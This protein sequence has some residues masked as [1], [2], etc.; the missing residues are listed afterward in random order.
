MFDLTRRDILTQFAALALFPSLA[1]ASDTKSPLQFDPPEPFSFDLLVERAREMASRPYHPETVRNGDVLQRIDFDEHWKI[2]YRPEATLEI[3]DGKAPVRFFHLGRYFQL[4]VNIHVVGGDTSQRLIYD[5]SLFCMPDDSPAR[6]LPHDIGFAGFRVLDPGKETDWLAI[7]GAAYFRSSGQSG[8]YGLSARAVALDTAMPT[9]EEFPRFT[10]F[11][12]APS[13]HGT[14]VINCLING[15]R[16][17]G[18]FR[19][20]CKKDGPVVMDISARFFARQDIPRVGLAPL[21]SMFWYS[22]TDPSRRKDWRPEIHDSDGLAIWSGNGERLWRPLNDPHRV[23]TSS[24]M[25]TSP[26]GF[27]LLQRDRNFE[28]YQDDGVFY[29]KRSSVWIEPKGDWG[30]GAVQLVEIPTDDETSD[31]IVAYWVAEKPVKAGDEL[32]LDYLLTWSDEEPHLS[33]MGR[34]VATRLG[35]GG[36]PGQEHPEGFVKFVV[37][38]DGGPVAELPRFA[39]GI[40]AVVTAS[41]GKLTDI[42]CYS[43]KVGTAWRAMFDLTVEGTEPVEMRLYM[44]QDGKTLTETWAYQYLPESAPADKFGKG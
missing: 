2:K 4:P 43:V 3:A 38:F 19:M 14:I 41:R 10:D 20:D 42:S 8:Q 27:G 24:F 40:K 17:A 21:T 35:R 11:Y 7:L 12:L 15:P 5:P 32:A 33:T 30:K 9:A 16:I 13:E 39:E 25:D 22:E 29:D 18:A 1:R 44:T 23:M 37:D 31:N 36:R 26:K 28:N 6:E 34:V